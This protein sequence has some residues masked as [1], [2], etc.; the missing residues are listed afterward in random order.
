MM[1]ITESSDTMASISPSGSFTSAGVTSLVGVWNRNAEGESL[2][3]GESR[4]APAAVGASEEP[5]HELGERVDREEVSLMYRLSGS[6]GNVSSRQESTADS[7]CST[8]SAAEQISGKYLIRDLEES[9][10]EGNES[11]SRLGGGD[12][13]RVKF[14]VNTMRLDQDEWAGE[15]P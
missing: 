15:E 3:P 12:A 8:V 6:C 10:P 4:P 9:N 5:N 14:G 13:A 7:M 11:W 2:H 1:A